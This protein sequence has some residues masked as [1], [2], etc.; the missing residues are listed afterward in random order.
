MRIERTVETDATP[1][2]VFAY[3]SDFTT[4]TEW[5]PGTVVTERI[6]G[7]GGVGTRY[8]N[9]SEF[10]GRKTEL[11]Y[12]AVTLEAPSLIVLQ[13]SNKTVDATDRME[14]APRAGGGTR[15]TYSADFAFKGLA[16]LATPF[17]GGPLGKLGDEAQ[18]GMRQALARLATQS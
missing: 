13:G 14:I 5:D 4:T 2:A 9:V 11:E 15:V 16:K 10:R 3:L 17:L 7:D 1:E 12:R 18:E 8:R 6:S